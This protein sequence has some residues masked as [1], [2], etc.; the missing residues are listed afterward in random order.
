MK[1]VHLLIILLFIALQSCGQKVDQDVSDSLIASTGDFQLTEQHFKTYLQYIE[2]YAGETADIK[3]QVVI[4]SQLKETFLKAPEKLLQQLEELDNAKSTNA[5]EL[6][7]QETR[8][9]IELNPS[10]NNRSVQLA[11]GHKIVRDLL[12]TDI[13]EMQFD[14]DAANTF[15]DYMTSTLLTA[16]SSSSDT[17]YGSSS[18]TDSNAQI[19]FCANGTFTEALSGHVSIQGSSGTGAV[20]SGTSYMPGYWEAAALPNGMLVVIMYSTHPRMLEDSPN[21]ILPFI[22]AKHGVDFVALPSGDL[23]RRT[24]N[25]YCQ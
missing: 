9:L 23:Y 21:G 20:S 8:S 19:Q 15:R 14:T 24:T 6:Q 17:S 25:Y 7:Y 11:E 10:P 16:Q 1:Q 22:V 5:T 2:D 4:K 18:Y 3:T 12:G 13:G